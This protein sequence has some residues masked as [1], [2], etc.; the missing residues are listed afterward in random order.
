MTRQSV[1][2]G[3]GS[4]PCPGIEAWQEFRRAERRCNRMARLLGPAA[5]P[6]FDR[7]LA[8]SGGFA[9]ALPISETGAALKLEDARAIYYGSIDPGDPIHNARSEEHTSELK[10]LMRTSYAAF[11]L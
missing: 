11:R 1:D 2:S 6:W 5:L 4:I 7:L 3:T 10:S 9:R 8:A